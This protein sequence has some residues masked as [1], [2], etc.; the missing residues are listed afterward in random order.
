[1]VPVADQ[2]QARTTNFTVTAAPAAAAA[3]QVR[4]RDWSNVLTAHEGDTAAYVWRLQH[5]SLGEHILRPPPKELVRRAP[6][7]WGS[8]VLRLG[9][10][11]YSATGWEEWG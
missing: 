10:E 3:E 7:F 4:E 2:C 6:S 11:P 9:A 8:R 1:V 5:F